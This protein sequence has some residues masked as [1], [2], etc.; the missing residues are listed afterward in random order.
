MFISEG[1]TE[2]IEMCDLVETL[3]H[4]SDH[5]PIGTILD[6]SLQYT[7]PDTRYSY[8]QTNTKVFNSTLSALLPLI[9]TTPLTLEVLDIYFTQLMN[10]ISNA[11]HISTSQTVPNVQ[12]TLGFDGFSNAACVKTNKARHH[13]KEETKQDPKSRGTKQAYVIYRKARVFKK[14]P[15]QS[16]LRQYRQKR[17]AEATEDVSKTW[18]LVRWIQNRATPYQVFTPYI[19]RQDGTKVFIRIT[20]AEGLAKSF[21]PQ[22]PNTNLED[23]SHKAHPDPVAYLTIDIKE[24]QKA[25]LKFPSQSAPGTDNIPKKILKNGLLLITPSLYWL[26]NS[27]LNLG[28][29]PRHF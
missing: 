8:D 10:A 3:D 6:L 24:I 26:F 4:D 11:I 2:K 14:R 12:V 9:P 27:S 25:I 15:V 1:L 20:K 13:V 7:A 23:I 19:K 22:V 5:L 16:T 28:Y 29:C 17:I 21:L 18:M